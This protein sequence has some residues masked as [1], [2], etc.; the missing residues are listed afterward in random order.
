MRLGI[1]CVVKLIRPN[2][3]VESLGVISSEVVII[4]WIVVRDR[5]DWVNFRAE[6]TEEVNLL[7]TLW[8]GLVS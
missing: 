4:F 3:V 6:H 7:L 5:R 8:N 1:R 2:R